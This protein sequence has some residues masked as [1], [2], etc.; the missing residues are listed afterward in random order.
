MSSALD[1]NAAAGV[2]AE[3]FRADMTSAMGEC[4]GCGRRAP[5]A[6]DAVFGGE[7]GWVLRCV[8]CG[9][10]LLRLVRAEGRAWLDLSGLTVVQLSLPD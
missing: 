1:G 3:V 8:G 10:V 2:L 9:A 4:A 7:L 6:D 5:L